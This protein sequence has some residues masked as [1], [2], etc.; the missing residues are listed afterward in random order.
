LGV[1]FEGT[2][3]GFIFI[4]NADDVV[5]LDTSLPGQAYSFTYKANDDIAHLWMLNVL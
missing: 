4:K 2:S 3:T 1:T 5:G